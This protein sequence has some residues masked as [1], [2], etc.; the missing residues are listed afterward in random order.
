MKD[1]LINKLRYRWY[2]LLSSFVKLGK[3]GKF[4]IFLLNNQNRKILKINREVII[5]MVLML[6]FILNTH[7][8]KAPR[9]LN[10]ID[11]PIIVNIA[12]SNLSLLI[13]H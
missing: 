2:R 1:N 8:N 7:A 11:K 10:A 9:G 4:L 13:M 12:T 5:I 6:Y 3:L